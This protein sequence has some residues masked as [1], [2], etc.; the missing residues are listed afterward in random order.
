MSSVAAVA[1]KPPPSLHE[2]GPA[3][4]RI[5]VDPDAM[6]YPVEA[7]YL[8]ALSPRTLETLRIRGGGPAFCRIGAR[9][10]RY[11]RSALLA[12]C[13]SRQRENTSA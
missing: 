3:G 12:W 13:T 8:V 6:L 4:R 1:T 2:S 11:K 9:A 5:P 10:I 7:A